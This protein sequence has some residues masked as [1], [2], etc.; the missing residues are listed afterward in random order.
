MASQPFTETRA[1]ISVG[2]VFGRSVN[3]IKANPVATLGV[4]FAMV[5]LPQL[6]VGLVVGR[7][8]LT[9]EF[10]D[11]A[12]ALFSLY[13]LAVLLLWL[14]AGGA[15]THAA[16]AHDQGRR[17]DLREILR[18]G[19]ARALP[20]LAVN[21]L[22]F[23]GIW[24]GFA[25]LI[26]PGI[27]LAVMWSV[28]MYAIAAERTGVFGAFGRSRALTKGARWHVFGILLLAFVIYL[29]VSIVAGV[30][31]VAGYGSFGALTGGATI[32]VPT[33][34]SVIVQLLQALITTVLVTWFTLVG[35]ALF[36]E[37]RH[38]KDG[39]D[40]DRLSEIFA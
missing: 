23:I 5:A 18:L 4:T 33:S 20:M 32:H 15:L 13:G 38:W 1:G 31:S 21:I 40:V 36:I 2:G 28:A 10:Q 37:L 3:I 22:F 8:S 17:A 6:L 25:V 34:P 9:R 29:L 16:I 11:G 27:I 19:V 12:Y 35:A 26:V 24:I 39:P 7:A 30:A 14:V